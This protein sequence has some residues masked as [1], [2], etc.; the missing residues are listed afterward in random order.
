MPTDY[1]TPHPQDRLAE[2]TDAA[3]RAEERNTQDVKKLSDAL[4]AASKRPTD[5]NHRPFPRLKVTSAKD[6][7]AV[8]AFAELLVAC[9]R[10]GSVLD[11]RQAG[12]HVRDWFLAVRKGDEDGALAAVASAKREL[13]GHLHGAEV[14]RIY[15]IVS[16]YVHELRNPADARVKAIISKLADLGFDVTPHK[17]D[18]TLA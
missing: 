17:A 16:D 12:K 7:E 5:P 2:A 18:A 8:A 1:A 11:E 6:V 10:A 13:A 9:D 14:S 3:R 4:D 15:D